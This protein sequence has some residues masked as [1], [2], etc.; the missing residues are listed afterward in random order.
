MP[1]FEEDIGQEPPVLWPSKPSP[2]KPFLVI[3]KN[4]LDFANQEASTHERE[5]VRKDASKR[6]EGQ[7]TPKR[8]TSSE[9]SIPTR[10]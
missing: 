6:K 2:T 1:T 7:E 8:Y 4:G 3:L 9:L 5:G 10:E